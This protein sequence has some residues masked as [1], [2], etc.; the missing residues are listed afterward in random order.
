EDLWFTKDYQGQKLSDQGDF[1]EAAERF[2][3]PLR[4]GV[5]YYKAGNYE[6]AIQEFKNDTSAYG[7][8][9]LGLAY[10]KNGDYYAAQ[11]AFEEAEEM[12]PTMDQA[13]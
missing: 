9:N 4:K 11:D 5:A 13:T 6:A 10:Y 3:D 2:E 8:Y 7:A 1:E 12:D